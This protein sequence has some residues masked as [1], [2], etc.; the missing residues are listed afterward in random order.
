MDLS[1]KIDMKTLAYGK[2]LAVWTRQMNVRAK[3]IDT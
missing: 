3:K 2:K 1:N